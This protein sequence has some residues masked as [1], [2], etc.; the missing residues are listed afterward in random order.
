[1]TPEE[2]QHS[3]VVMITKPGKDLYKT[4]RWRPINLINCVRKLVEKVVVYVYRSYDSYTDTNSARSKED[5]GRRQ[6]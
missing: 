1:V 3:K 4:K 6:H 2:W 5:P